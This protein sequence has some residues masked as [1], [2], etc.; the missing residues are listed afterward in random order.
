MQ[1]VVYS[2]WLVHP[3]QHVPLYREGQTG[4]LLSVYVDIMKYDD[5]CLLL[6]VDPI[7][8]FCLSCSTLFVDFNYN[9][10]VIFQLNVLFLVV[11]LQGQ[12]Q[13]QQSISNQHHLIPYLS[14]LRVCSIAQC[15]SQLQCLLLYQ[16]LPTIFYEKVFMVVKT[17][18]LVPMI[19]NHQGMILV[20]GC[21]IVLYQT[22]I[23]CKKLQII[24]FSQVCLFWARQHPPHN[25][26][27]DMMP[28]VC[29][30]C[31]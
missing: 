26:E 18:N 20:V 15:C 5:E 12:C 4:F 22:T 1:P 19:T 23:V 29:C 13:A 14:F 7:I 16:S 3:K 27:R 6:P 17:W 9:H 31:C 30:L 10:S 2:R 24:Y 8:D 11:A 21:H 28:N 25:V